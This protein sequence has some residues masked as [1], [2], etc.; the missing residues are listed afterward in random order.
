[1]QMRRELPPHGMNRWMRSWYGLVDARERGWTVIFGLLGDF[2]ESECKNR[3][4]FLT[5][6]KY[7]RSG[8]VT[9]TPN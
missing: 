5:N 7:L 4:I 6:L 2:T 8:G 9:F 3:L 1:M